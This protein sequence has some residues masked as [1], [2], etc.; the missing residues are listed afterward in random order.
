M[1][2]IDRFHWLLPSLL[3]AAAAVGL[4]HHRRAL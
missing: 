3:R 2:I 1:E 4:L